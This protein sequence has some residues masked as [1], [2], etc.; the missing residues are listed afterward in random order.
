MSY[1][2]DLKIDINEKYFIKTM[3][4]IINEK[5]IKEINIID[6]TI[7]NEN[8]VYIYNFIYENNDVNVEDYIKNILIKI[9]KYIK[10][11]FHEF[12][13][14]WQIKHELIKQ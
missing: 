9:E 5:L 2:L 4:H 13:N 12:N 3:Q 14:K 1:L 10:V 11:F 8:Q 7:K 6:L